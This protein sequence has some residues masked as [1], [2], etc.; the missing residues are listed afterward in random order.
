MAWWMWMVLGLGLAVAEAL[1]PTNFFLLAF[2]IGG[3][4]IGA[5][6]GLG[7][8][9]EPWLEWLTFTLVSIAAV[10]VFQRTLS[11]VP[12]ERKVDQ[13]QGERA[14][15]TEDIPPNGV[16]R[17]ELRGA[18]W[19]ARSSGGTALTRGTLARVERV[20]GLTLWLRPE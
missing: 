8:I 7:W 4:A 18:T 19:T 6:D 3:L 1:I 14:T 10:V 2:G 20:D 13:I 5:L 15:V 17:A 12:S 16:G 11:R 9:N